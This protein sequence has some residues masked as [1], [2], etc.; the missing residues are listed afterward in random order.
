MRAPSAHTLNRWVAYCMPL[1]MLGVL[2]FASWVFCKQICLDY[3]ATERNYENTA[4]VL[5]TIYAFLLAL[6][7]AS[8]TRVVWTINFNP[9]LVPYGTDSEVAERQKSTGSPGV[10]VEREKTQDVEDQD[11]EARSTRARRWPSLRGRTDGSEDDIQL[12]NGQRLRAVPYT[13]TV[14]PSPRINPRTPSPHPGD[15]IQLP[16]TP[17][18]THGNPDHRPTSMGPD[19]YL[20]MPP[21]LNPPQRNSEYSISRPQSLAQWLLPKNLQEFYEMDAFICESDGLPKWCF[22]CNCWKPDRSHHCGEIGRCVRKMDHFCPW[23]GG[24]VSETSFKFFY[25]TVC[26]TVLYCVFVLVTT[27][28]MVHNRATNNY[29]IP[30]NWIG[31]LALTAAF[32]LFS[33]GMAGTT[34]QFIIQN[35]STIDNLSAATKVYQIAIYDPY[36]PPVPVTANSRDSAYT[37][38]TAED[39]T[40]TLHRFP[41]QLPSPNNTK[42]LTF[43]DSDPA[44]A[45]IGAPRRTFAIAKTEPGENP[46]RLDS[47]MEN[48]KEVMGERVW[49]WFLPITSSPCTKRYLELRDLELG[50]RQKDGM[51]RFN[52]RIMERLRRECGIGMPT[53]MLN[54][55]GR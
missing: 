7:F 1:V 25:Q 6:L 39:G 35:T 54:G 55:N 26:Y 16:Q 27:S 38:A 28:V 14:S 37:S 24:V 10:V 4:I 12:E 32:G 21:H 47:N 15:H 30:G 36:A 51:Y 45:N 40:P 49:E 9:G 8:Y 22:H 2:G 11:T 33:S 18:Q 19:G 43:P 42:R 52:P 31:V 34:S 3:L 13:T 46:W 23:V 29:G 50:K 44:L 48:F 5:L 20:Q 17:Q 41:S 53:P